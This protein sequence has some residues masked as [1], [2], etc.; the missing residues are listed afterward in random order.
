[1]EIVEDDEILPHRLPRNNYT[2]NLWER[3]G[4]IGSLRNFTALR[5]LEAPIFILVGWDPTHPELPKLGDI[6]P[7]SLEELCLRDDLI[8]IE[9][10][11]GY[12]WTPWYTRSPFLFSKLDH[13]E[14][15]IDLRRKSTGEGA[16]EKFGDPTPIIDQI[17]QL[18]T[19]TTPVSL[20][21]NSP[22][23]VMRLQHL[24]IKN[25]Q[26]CWW[27]DTY[28]ALLTKTC[29]T[30]GVSC[31]FH[32]RLTNS[33]DE[34]LQTTY[35]QREISNNGEDVAHGILDLRY[36]LIYEKV[37]S[38]YD[39]G[40]DDH[41]GRGMQLRQKLESWGTDGTVLDVFQAAGEQ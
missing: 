35:H 34:V 32:R 39:V 18:L 37:G 26:G 14:H 8:N 6:L 3:R 12:P 25:R 38:F 33:S 28:A 36:K 30:A 23:P 4:S 5:K 41:S 1:M 24:I 11:F 22:L 16:F 20:G 40:L 15:W 10:E 7:D 21:S 27:R 31:T 13:Y 29:E 9:L 2:K 17:C 19:T